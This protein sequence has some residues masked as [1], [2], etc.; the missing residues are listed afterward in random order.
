M[1]EDTELHRPVALYKG[2][3]FINVFYQK[4]YV[5]GKYLS[6]ATLACLGVKVFKFPCRVIFSG[7]SEQDDQRPKLVFA[8]PQIPL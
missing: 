6:F 4:K 3:I 7:F 1:F 8:H 2:P 5:Y